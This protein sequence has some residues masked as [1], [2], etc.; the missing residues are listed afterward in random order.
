MLKDLRGQIERITYINEENGFTV[1]K[2][3]V[4]GERNLVVITGNFI[5]LCPGEILKMKGEWKN[6]PK[7]GEQFNVESYKTEVPGTVYGIQKYLGS[8][9][10]KG[11]GPVMAKRI[12]KK[13]GEKALDTIENSINSLAKV[14]GVGKKRIAMIKEAWEA[15]KEIRDVIIF[16]QTHGVSSG[17]AAKIFKEYGKQSIRVLKENPFRLAMD[18]FGIGFVTA[19]NIAQK[20]GFSKDSKIR[21]EAGI[22]YVLHQLADEGHTYYPYEPLISKCSEILETKRE[23][24]ES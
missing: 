18:I 8:G 11:I 9:L 20:L 10:I 7:F 3:K 5:A 22:I 21:L 1:A 15:Q 14:E 23:T 17:Y 24:I 2:I 6:H 19:D 13:F 16:L 12:V 4:I